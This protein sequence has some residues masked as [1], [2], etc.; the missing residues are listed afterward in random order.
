MPSTVYLNLNVTR[1]FFCSLKSV[2]DVA[3]ALSVTETDAREFVKSALN[4]L[5]T[6]FKHRGIS[7]SDLALRDMLTTYS[8]QSAPPNLAVTINAAIL[9]RNA[10]ISKSFLSKVQSILKQY[11]K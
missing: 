8:V 11:R 2:A 3:F 10:S 6:F 9:N 5:R 4:T 7:I 1:Y